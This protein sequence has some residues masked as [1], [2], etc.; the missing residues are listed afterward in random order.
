[1]VDIHKVEVIDLQPF[2]H[3]VEGIL[4]IGQIARNLTCYPY[5][6]AGYTTFLDTPSRTA[7]VIVE[8]GIVQMAISRLKC[9]DDHA[10]HGLIELLPLT[11]T[12]H[13]LHLRTESEAGHH[14]TIVEPYQRHTSHRLDV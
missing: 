1:M 12:L 14:H 11:S 6:F 8:H 10:A 4:R 2:E 13:A 3:A 7:L 9:R 5:L